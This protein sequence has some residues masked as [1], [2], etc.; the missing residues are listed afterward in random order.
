MVLDI[1]GQILSVF[2]L[3]F[4]ENEGEEGYCAFDKLFTKSVPHILEKIFLF[5]D[6]ESFKKE[7]LAAAFMF[8]IIYSQ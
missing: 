2:G 5:L 1:M 3:E 8:S 4:F 7:N 6:F